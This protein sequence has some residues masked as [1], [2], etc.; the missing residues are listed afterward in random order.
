[1]RQTRTTWRRLKSGDWQQSVSLTAPLDPDAQE[2]LETW[3]SQQQD[4]QTHND[5]LRCPMTKDEP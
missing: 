5:E 4:K 1:M 2:F 3:T